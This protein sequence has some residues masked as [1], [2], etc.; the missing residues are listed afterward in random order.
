MNQFDKIQTT[1]ASLRFI[2]KTEE[3]NLTEAFSRIL[4][5]DVVADINMPPFD[6]SAMDGY[7]CRFEDVGQPMRML[8][9]ISAGSVPSKK[10]G[11]NECSKIMTG[12]AVPEGADCVFKVEDSTQLEDGKVICTNPKTAK[13]ICYLGEDYKTG[14][15]LISKRTKINESHLA[16]LAGAGYSRVKVSSLPKVALVTTGSELVEPDQVPPPGKIRN[17]NASQ[18]SAQLKK[19]G[20]EVNYLGLAADDYQKLSDLVS[21]AFEKF[22]IL[23]F[24]G[25]ASVGDFDFIPHILKEQNFTVLWERSGLKP[26]NPITVAQKENK[27]CIGLSGNPV[28]SLVQFEFI[29]KPLLYRLM[30]CDIKPRKIKASMASNFHRKK[31]DRIAVIPVKINN[32]GEVETIP[33]HGS[34]HINSLVLANALIEV[35]VGQLEIQ[36]GDFVYV[37]PI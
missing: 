34:A 16:V 31:A 3:I 10:I 22:D 17:S 2:T 28:S 4:Q 9:I 21:S 29:A 25:G 20:I 7:A 26:G 32:E 12:A 19:M 6:K 24:T 27:Y 23:I 14:E 33:F 11:E 37:R 35:P 13:N 15:I 5:E 18:V 1:I 30:N 8:E 36:K